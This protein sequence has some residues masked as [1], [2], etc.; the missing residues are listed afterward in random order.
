MKKFDTRPHRVL[1][2]GKLYLVVCTISIT[3]CPA[4]RAT[5]AEYLPG[6]EWEEPRQVTPGKNNQDP[7]SDAVILFDGVDTNAWNNAETWSVTDGFLIVGKGMISTKETFG[8][9]QLHVEWSSPLP[10][11][12]TGQGRGNSGVFFGPYEIQVLDSF[13]NATYFDGQAAAIYKQT[14][15]LVNV[16]RKPGA[17]NSY[18]I[19]W[20]TPRFDA[21]G[22]LTE[23]ATVT[24]L[25]NGVLVQNNFELLGDTPFN[26]PPRYRP[27]PPDL[28]IRLQDHRNPVRFR[29]I[30]VRKIAP[31]QGKRT[32][33]P[34]L[35]DEKKSTK[36]PKKG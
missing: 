8:D 22:G 6:I 15:P 28:P 10:A 30:W 36:R 23:P 2:L 4:L 33:P 26:R 21:E 25:H 32:Q 29:N 34:T 31:I 12:G 17:W 27:H 24:V 3:I 13:E 16:M 18:D 20:N 9:C 11:E 7:P 19:I 1:T 5:A 35:R 14:P